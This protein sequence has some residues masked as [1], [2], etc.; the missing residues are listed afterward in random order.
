MTR[1]SITPNGRFLLVPWRLKSTKSFSETCLEADAGK[2]NEFN[3][4]DPPWQLVSD[5]L[6]PQSPLNPTHRIRRQPGTLPTTTHSIYP[7]PNWDQSSWS[8][9]SSARSTST[10]SAPTTPSTPSWNAP[11]SSTPRL[12]WWVSSSRSRWSP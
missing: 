1:C 8:Q 12:A 6:Q 9:L 2:V 5:L 4:T 7:L 11:S 10:S 3:R